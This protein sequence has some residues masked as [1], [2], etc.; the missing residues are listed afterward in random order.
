MLTRVRDNKREV[1]GRRRQQCSNW[2]ST[3]KFPNRKMEAADDSK[4]PDKKESA[5]A[6]G[7]T[8]GWSKWEGM[9]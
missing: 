8:V 5:G 4:S 1:T 9:R 2:R 3:P 7:K 6:N